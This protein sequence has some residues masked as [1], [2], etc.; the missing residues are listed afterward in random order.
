M[1]HLWRIRIFHVWQIRANSSHVWQIRSN[2]KVKRICQMCGKLERICHTCEEFVRLFHRCDKY[3]LIP[4]LCEGLARIFQRWQMRIFHICNTYAWRVI[5][6]YKRVFVMRSYHGCLSPLAQHCVVKRKMLRRH[7]VVL[8]E[9]MT[10]S[11]GHEGECHGWTGIYSVPVLNMKIRGMSGNPLFIFPINE[12]LIWSQIVNY[13]AE[14]HFVPEQG[15]S[16]FCRFDGMRTLFWR[17]GSQKTWNVSTD[18]NLVLYL[19][20]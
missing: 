20:N 10:E 12:S 3:V 13:T 16:I 11:G 6:S 1:S 18:Q 9:T 8:K 5:N 17:A 4:R 15:W 14:I 2:V 19:H 7:P